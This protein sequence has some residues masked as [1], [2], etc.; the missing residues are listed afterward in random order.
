MTTL[1]LI[2]HATNPAIKGGRLVGRSPGVH[3]DEEG[4]AQASALAERLADVELAA[5]YTS[6]LERAQET[7]QPLA[8]RHGLEARP[9]PGLLETDCGRWQGELLSK[10]R[11]RP[12]WRELWSCP[13]RVTFPGGEN[14]WQM[15]ARM[16]AALEE[17]HLAHP[18][19]TV[20]VVSHADPLR[21]VIACYLGGPFD[22]YQRLTISP[23]SLTVLVL[24]K[25]LPRLV[26]LNDTC[27]L[28]GARN[29]QGG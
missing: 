25:P 29:K 17:I 16:T 4:R 1:L 3:L 19:E 22:L 6:P 14:A 23:A 13:S 9:H 18:T 12:L 2:R 28:P 10:L 8:A 20:A 27:H 24:D 7:A 21:A 26:C 5:V 15:A 11:R